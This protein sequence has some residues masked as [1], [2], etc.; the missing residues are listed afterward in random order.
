M[1][2]IDKEGGIDLINIKKRVLLISG[3][4]LVVLSI[5]VGA[6]TLNATN[7]LYQNMTKSIV[8]A[9]VFNEDNLDF[10]K[11]YRL[12]YL[13]NHKNFSNINFKKVVDRDDNTFTVGSRN[14]NIKG[15]DI[16]NQ[17]YAIHLLYCEPQGRYC[18]FRINGVPAAR[19]HSFLE[20]ENS[21]I[22]FFDIDEDYVLKVNSIKFNQCDNKRFCHLGYEGYHVVDVSIERK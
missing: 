12:K 4:V 16:N 10:D 7:N 18:A 8:L 19:L 22:T 2:E 6:V 1:Y 11:S 21:K 9:K 17:S 13:N 20:V 14:D 15:F 5:F 3:V